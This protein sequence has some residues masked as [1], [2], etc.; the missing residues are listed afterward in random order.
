MR[1]PVKAPANAACSGI[2]TSA[3]EAHNP[4]TAASPTHRHGSF[5][6]ADTTQIVETSSAS[7]AGPTTSDV[8]FWC[9]T[10]YCR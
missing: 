6:A 2:C 9:A 1:L 3:V 8:R 5:V 7:I 4:A 10:W